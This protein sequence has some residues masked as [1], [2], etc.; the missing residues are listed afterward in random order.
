[1]H[2]ERQF[3]FRGNASG[4]AA[5]I[6]RPTDEMIPVQAASS[7]PT[8]GGLSESTA[9]GQQFRYI[10]FDSAYTR[11]HG[12]YD[13]REGAIDITWRKRPAD[14][15]PTTTTVISE[16]KGFR[17]LENV[18]AAR[19]RAEMTA[20]SPRHHHHETSVTPRGTALE[21]LFIN[22]VELRVRLN[23]EFFAKHDTKEE[24]ERAMF[25][26]DEEARRLCL[27]KSAGII[28][29]T[30]VERLEWAGEAPKGVVIENNSV[31]I[32]D[33]GTLYLA[34][35]FIGAGSRRLNMMRAD[36]GS[37]TGGQATAGSIETN[38][39]TWPAAR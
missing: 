2:I 26:G 3:L 29:A 30:L 15:I 25:A 35:M 37:P 34:E 23:E 21:G 1:M 19:I 28:Y 4:V 13:D 11:S 9:E 12:D 14:S 38:G 32:P 24:L 16:V 8:I 39:S 31:R 17:I 20:R 10:G 27:F 6:R 18:R 7:V 36:M 5:H 33:F 22:G